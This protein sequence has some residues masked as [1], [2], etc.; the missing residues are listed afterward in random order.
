M[1]RNASGVYSLPEPPVV[2]LTTI[3]SAD[4]NSTRNDIGA[5]ITNSLDRNGRGAMLAA[6][7]IIDG[8]VA[9]PGLRFASDVNCGA[10]RVSADLW[11]LVAGGVDVARLNGVASAVNYLDFFP[12]ITGVDPSIVPNGTDTN[13]SLVINGKGTGQGK[14]GGVA[15]N[16]LV[17]RDTAGTGVTEDIA[18]DATLEFTGAQVVRRAALTGDVTAPAGSN[19][20]T[21]A[22]DAVTYAKM[23]NVSATNRVLGRSTAGAGDP[24]EITVGGDITQSGSTFTI[25]NNAVSFAKMQDINTG[26]VV[27]RTTAA[28]GD[29]EEI[30]VQTANGLSFAGGSLDN[31]LTGANVGSG[32]GLVFR[33]KTGNNINFKRI[34]AG[35]QIGVVNGAND[36]TINFLASP[37]CPGTSSIHPDSLVEMHDGSFKWL[38]DIRLGDMVRGQDGPSEVLGIYRTSL[39]RRSLFNVNGTVVTPDHLFKTRDGW[40]CCDPATYEETFGRVRVIKTKGGTSSAINSIA[41]IDQVSKLE[42]GMEVLSVEGWTPVVEFTEY[43]PFDEQKKDQP[44]T[45]VDQ[46]VM[47]LKL[48]DSEY[49]FSDG[50]AVAALG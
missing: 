46:P 22:N 25:G 34:L 12:S 23:Q 13:R 27:G 32:A 6:L 40:A 45:N 24:E 21:I 36:V 15:T 47:S 18:L 26:R 11:A 28:S 31:N 39:A 20:Q 17:G 48:R 29:P 43:K 1:P 2:T 37:V 30:T 10:Y 5:E 3:E 38:G 41:P 19:A 49:F 44:S 50:Y 8:A 7:G 9:T 16:R 14:L 35:T 42:H 33:D 4:E